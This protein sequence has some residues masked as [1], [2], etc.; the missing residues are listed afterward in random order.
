[1]K[2]TVQVNKTNLFEKI[3]NASFNRDPI[4]IKN[5]SIKMEF[6]KLSLVDLTQ[7][8]KLDHLRNY[9]CFSKYVACRLKFRWTWLK[10]WPMREQKWIHLTNQRSGNCGWLSLLIVQLVVSQHVSK[11]GSTNFN[12]IRIKYT[13]KNIFH[14]LDKLQVWLYAIWK[15]TFVHAEINQKCL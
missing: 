9:T 14:K 4:L 7:N 11:I 6:P 8:L 5:I 3:W 10:H 13:I 15:D 2:P 12:L 1:M